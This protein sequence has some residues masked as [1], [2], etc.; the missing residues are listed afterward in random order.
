MEYHFRHSPPGGSEVE[1]RASL[2]ATNFNSEEAISEPRMDVC[3]W[4]RSAT[5]M[6]RASRILGFPPSP[7]F[8]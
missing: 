2:S 7:Y 6:I 4:N 5:S 1:N 8:D 3:S